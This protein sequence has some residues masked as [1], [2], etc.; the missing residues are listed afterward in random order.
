[1]A[2]RRKR[3]RK[4]R[5]HTGVHSSPKAGECHYRSGWE[6]EYMLHLDADAT[7]ASY[8]YEQLQIPYVSNVRTGRLRNYFPDFLV[9][10][11]DGSQKLVEIKP[12]KR[13][14]QVTVV[15][16]LAAAQAWCS[17]HGVTLELVTEVE[18]KALGLL[19]KNKPG[20]CD[21]RCVCPGYDVSWQSSWDSTFRR[22]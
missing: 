21:L 12:K 6:L 5:Y 16:K 1:M 19:K 4:G 7:V 15:K 17:E 22:R 18:L 2:K 9:A 10:Y 8:Q 11:V 3:K 20:S 14:T 13:S